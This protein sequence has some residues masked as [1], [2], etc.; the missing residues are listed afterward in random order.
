MPNRTLLAAAALSL[1]IASPAFAGGHGHHHQNMGR[2]FK[3]GNFNVS[4][5]RLFSAIAKDERSQLFSEANGTRSKGK[6]QV[7]WA[8][9]GPD[10]LVA[11]VQ[12]SSS[13]AR[14]NAS[15]PKV[16]WANSGPD[17]LVAPVQAPGL[18]NSSSATKQSGQ[19]K[20]GSPRR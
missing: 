3:S 11:P 16:V 12:A 1:T 13:M 6:A 9:S 7:I 10:C 2:A 14:G 4:D 15:K 5:D 17:C 20:S 18:I 8:N 19:E